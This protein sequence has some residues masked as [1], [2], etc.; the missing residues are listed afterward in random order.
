MR[1]FEIE[2]LKE[3]TAGLFIGT[4]FDEFLLKE[5]SIITYCT[6][7]V[8]G[9]RMKTFYEPQE[10]EEAAGSDYVSWSEIKPHLFAVIRGKRPPVHFKIVLILPED[11]PVCRE[12]PEVSS[13]A[14]EST[15]FLNIVYKNKK[16]VCTTGQSMAGF[17]PG[18]HADSSW[19][20]A[21]AQ[22]LRVYL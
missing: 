1:T 16:L 13:Q 21:A 17:V 10:Y 22:L 6:F 3:F 8:D 14:S 19:D 12:N 4:L 15:L 9:E 5:A 11:H 20:D 2:R 18:I 7:H